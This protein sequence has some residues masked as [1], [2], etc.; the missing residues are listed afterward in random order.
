[1]KQ[2]TFV[3]SNVIYRRAGLKDDCHL[4]S[5]L[6]D[7][8]MDSWVN[9]T[10]EREPCYFDADGLI[11]NDLTVI[12]HR[13][14]HPDSIVG[15][16]SF[17]E[18]PVHINGEPSKAGY[19]GALRV[20]PQYRHK[21]RLIKNG[22]KSIPKLVP[23]LSV[24]PICFTSLAKQNNNARRLL[25]A[26][27]KGMPK[28]AIYGEIQTLAIS[29]ANSQRFGFFRPLKT[30]EIPELIQFYNRFSKNYQLSPVLSKDWLL[31]LNHQQGL[32]LD[33]FYIAKHLGKI[34]ACFAIWD[35]R[36]VKQVV[37][38]AY[39]FP[40]NQLRGLYNLYAGFTKRVRLPDINEQLPQAYIA[41]FAYDEVYT[42]RISYLIKEILYF[43]QTK[44][45]EIGVIGLSIK[46]PA[47][48]TIK[49]TMSVQIYETIIETVNFYD[50][51]MFQ[52]DSKPAQPEVAIL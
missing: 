7:N 23:N 4:K 19:L 39:K 10:F 22:F 29:T 17:A 52:L 37:V 20:N 6:R 27:I 32:S 51:Q 26:N 42:S 14:D 47:L 34:K 3:A 15:M 38:K 25:E 11:G 8:A 2:N 5:T 31:N 18:L 49:Q 12:A 9:M 13:F 33:D 1:M 43:I 16:Y 46:N 48:K 50:K 41:F 35:Q 40:L 36:S 21:I 44:Q 45:A 24:L 28:Y 30:D